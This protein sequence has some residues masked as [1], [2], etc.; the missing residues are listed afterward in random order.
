MAEITTM[1]QNTKKNDDS[2]LLYFCDFIDEQ[3]KFKNKICTLILTEKLIVVFYNGTK[4]VFNIKYKDIVSVEVYECSAD[5]F[6][7]VLSR[8]NKKNYIVTK[9]ESVCKNAYKIIQ[10]I[11]A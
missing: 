1:L 4:E 9:S 7:L 10:S 8:I 2:D 5:V 3:R 6:T 11:L